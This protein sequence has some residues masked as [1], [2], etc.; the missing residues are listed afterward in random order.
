MPDIRQLYLD[1]AAAALDALADPAVG[2]VWDEDSALAG[3]TVGSLAAH[4]GRALSTVRRYLGG[5]PPERD[6]ELLDAAEYVLRVLPDDD[7]GATDEGV[8]TRA[9]ADAADG[10]DV[11][12]R[13]ATDDLAALRRTL[14]HLSDGHVLT[15]LDGLVML[16]DQYLATRIV[17]LVVHHDDLDVSVP[18]V[19]RRELPDG[20]G[21]IAVATLA[22]IARRRSSTTA[23]VR[24][25]ARGERAPEEAPRAF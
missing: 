12:I 16:L 23:V 10:H 19:P 24:F 7:D 18:G 11:V 5:P 9:A 25:L 8:R 22:E 1:T 13:R 14:P 17:E 15:V 6:P 4:L 2:D 20:A 3:M 21:E